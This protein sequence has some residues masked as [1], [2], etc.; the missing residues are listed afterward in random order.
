MQMRRAPVTVSCSVCSR[1][2]TRDRIDL[3]EEICKRAA[4]QN[5][6]VFNSV[7]QRTGEIAAEMRNVKIRRSVR[8]KGDWRSKRADFLRQARIAR[9]SLVFDHEPV[10]LYHEDENIPPD[11]TQ[12][13]SP[14]KIGKPVDLPV[15]TATVD[16]TNF[17]DCPP[18]PHRNLTTL[19]FRVFEEERCDVH[20]TTTDLIVSTTDVIV[21]ET[22]AAAGGSAWVVEWS[23]PKTKPQVIRKKKVTTHIIRGKLNTSSL[24]TPRLDNYYTRSDARLPSPSSSLPSSSPVSAFSFASSSSLRSVPAFGPARPFLLKPN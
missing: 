5:R 7:K 1:G 15:K 17:A 13:L 23:P 14:V 10:I 19:H 9:A 4:E 6:V 24:E 16:K 12:V 8:A 3:H 2:F 18:L 20:E 22:T 21:S 11:S